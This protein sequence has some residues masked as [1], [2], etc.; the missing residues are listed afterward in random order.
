MPT[1]NLPTNKLRDLIAVLQSLDPDIE[2]N[3]TEIEVI[4][5]GRRVMYTGEYTEAK[6]VE[7]IHDRCGI[8]CALD[9]RSLATAIEALFTENQDL[10]AERD[11]LKSQVDGIKRVLGVD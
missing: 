8:K 11:E 9:I 10:T 7:D 5:D 6:F 4:T 3:I 1:Y 2:H